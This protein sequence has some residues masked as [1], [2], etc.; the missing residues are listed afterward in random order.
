MVVE[1]AKMNDVRAEDYPVLIK[2]VERYVGTE[3]CPSVKAICSILGIEYKK[4][5]EV[6]IQVI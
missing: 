3:E 5:L 2:A 6:L 4:N 1:N